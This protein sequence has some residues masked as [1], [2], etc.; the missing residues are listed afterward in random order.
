MQG[1]LGFPDLQWG[2][3]DNRMGVSQIGPICNPDEEAFQALVPFE[4]SLAK[5]RRGRHYV[6]D[7]QDPAAI[8]A[9][10][11]VIGPIA[12]TEM[13]D[14]GRACPHLAQQ[15]EGQPRRGK[16]MVWGCPGG[17]AGGETSLLL[18]SN[19]S[20]HAEREPVHSAPSRADIHV[21]DPRRPSATCP[22]LVWMLVDLLAHS[23]SFSATAPARPQRAAN[24][25]S[26]TL[27]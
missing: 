16:Y 2:P 8:E 9:E 7:P 13:D 14:V 21:P 5:R 19:A 17:H 18:Q 4:A 11:H 24:E 23:G 26:V 15:L 12:A 3:A 22:S 25:C 6:G 27:A 20:L 1:P 10:D